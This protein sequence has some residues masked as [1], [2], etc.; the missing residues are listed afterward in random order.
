MLLDTAEKEAATASCVVGLG[1]GLYGGQDGGYGPAQSLYVSRGYKPDGEGV[2]Y[3]NQ[4]AIPGN[5]YLLDDELILLLT[6]NL[7]GS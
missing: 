2:T 7:S 5:Y 3:K 4:Q 6:K 1:V